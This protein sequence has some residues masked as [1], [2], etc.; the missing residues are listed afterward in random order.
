MN[1]KKNW[2]EGRSKLPWKSLSL[3]LHYSCPPLLPS[4]T[5]VTADEA[6]MSDLERGRVQAA[7]EVSGR[8]PVD[9]FWDAVE[10]KMLCV[11]IT[12]THK[13]NASAL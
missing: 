8:H 9:V 2:S 3:S 4:F 12:L 11:E 1:E 13:W 10:P 5:M 7:L 6:G